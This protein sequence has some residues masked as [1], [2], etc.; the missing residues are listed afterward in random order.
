MEFLN[1]V[2]L[3]SLFAKPVLPLGCVPAASCSTDPQSDSVESLHGKFVRT[4]SGG[5]MF[6]S[7]NGFF[8]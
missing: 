8:G 6:H 1:R 3:R 2:K 7:H 4:D 5:V